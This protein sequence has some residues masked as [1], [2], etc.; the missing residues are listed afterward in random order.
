MSESS[1]FVK[2]AAEEEDPFSAVTPSVLS[3]TRSSEPLRSPP[4]PQELRDSRSPFYAEPIDS[5]PLAKAARRSNPS[6]RSPHATNP[7][8]RRLRPLV[9]SGMT[10]GG[11]SGLGNRSL[12]GLLGGT[13]F[14][15]G[16]F[17]RLGGDLL[18]EEEHVDNARIDSQTQ[19]VE[20][21]RNASVAM[22][23]FW[24]QQILPRCVPTAPALR[25]V[26]RIRIRRR[27]QGRRR[28]TARFHLSSSLFHKS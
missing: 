7:P 23:D 3:P 1:I 24:L 14:G 13:R 4:A 11:S 21:E 8:N 10:V 20:F 27:G 19:S 28:S 17:E 26:L 22:A 6:S 9:N 5:F 2:E 15:M 25:H 12:M 16:A 18:E